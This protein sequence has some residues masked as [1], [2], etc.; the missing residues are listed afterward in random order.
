[1]AL[2]E[3]RKRAGAQPETPCK[4]KCWRS[5]EGPLTR[6][7]NIVASFLDTCNVKNKLPA[8]LTNPARAHVMLSA[9]VKTSLGVPA[10]ERHPY[11]NAVVEMIQKA[12]S[13]VENDMRESLEKSQQKVKDADAQMVENDTRIERM[14]DSVSKLRLEHERQTAVLVDKDTVLAETEKE[15]A[16]AK[17]A[18]MCAESRL[19]RSIERH[20]L[21]GTTL[22][23][24]FEQLKL[25]SVDGSEGKQILSQFVSAMGI[26]NFNSTLV[27][28]LPVILGKEPSE[29]TPFC[30]KTLECFETEAEDHNEQESLLIE[31]YGADKLEC[32]AVEEGKRILLEVLTNERQAAAVAMNDSER[33]ADEEYKVLVQTRSDAQ[34]FL[35]H[36]KRLTDE[37]TGKQS[38]LNAFLEGPL[39]AFYVLKHY[40]TATLQE[41]KVSPKLVLVAQSI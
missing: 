13:A 25:G 31:K 41:D 5:L 4:R 36:C 12:L 40:S 15:L 2:I 21:L 16:M 37:V 22:K 27:E 8:D 39:A 18:V 17:N 38:D 14:E 35:Q 30:N 7:C 20:T 24:L 1:M 10:K 9:M 26:C 19:A 34:E 3:N 29:R 32:N 23:P 11:Q 6:R 28:L 33:I